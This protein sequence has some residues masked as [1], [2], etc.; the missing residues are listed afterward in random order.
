MSLNPGMLYSV[1]PLHELRSLMGRAD[2]LFVYEKMIDRMLSTYAQPVQRLGMQE[3]IV[4]LG[5]RL[6]DEGASL[7][8]VILVKRSW[9]Q[10]QGRYVELFEADGLVRHQCSARNVAADGG[11]CIDPTGAGD[12]MAA[13]ILFSLIR[14]I[15]PQDA[16]D[17]A[18]V[19]AM[20]VESDYGG[21]AGLPRMGSLEFQWQRYLS[22]H[23][24]TP[25][26]LRAL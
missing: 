10:S 13:A 20:S 2:V 1:K 21:V 23:R 22:D 8:A 11:F 4:E 9:S 16:V 5:A 7:P 3:R 18:Y 17:L 15:P 19:M 14:D 25:D 24:D 26:W 6:A 12:S